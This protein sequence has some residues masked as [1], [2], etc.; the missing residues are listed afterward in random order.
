VKRELPLA[1]VVDAALAGLLAAIVVAAVALFLAI[2]LTATLVAA[3][4]TAGRTAGSAEAATAGRPEATAATTGR[5]IEATAA[6]AGIATATRRTT[7]TA[8]AS[9]WR[10]TGAAGVTTATAAISAG[11]A[12]TAGARTAEGPRSAALA[13]AR[14]VDAKHASVELLSVEL[15]QGLLCRFGGGEL[16]EGE[17]TR[18]TCLTVDDDRHARH[19]SS[20]RAECFSEGG[21]VRVVVQ[22]AHIELRSHG[23]GLLESTR[24]ANG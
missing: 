17:A 12:G 24:T 9:A 19:F 3:G 15:L 22:V 21:L 6:T 23:D 7:T 4:R 1:V 2:L 20:V 18:A 14:F 13:L 11:T 10:T 5:P 8:E 16:D